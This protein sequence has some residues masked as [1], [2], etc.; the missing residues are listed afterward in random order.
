MHPK[1]LVARFLAAALTLSLTI[2]LAFTSA[3]PANAAP[4]AD[5]ALDIITTVDVFPVLPSKIQV[6]QEGGGSELTAVTWDTAS[7]DRSQWSTPGTYY[8][9]GSYAGGTATVTVTVTAERGLPE[10][11]TPYLGWNSWYAMTRNISEASIKTQ[12]LALEAKGVTAAGY[13]IIWLD[14]GWWQTSDPYR[15]DD[16]YIA[17][18]SRFPDMGA[19][20]D[21]LHARGL[22][23][24]LYADPASRACGNGYGFGGDNW[25]ENYRKDVAQM[26]EWGVDAIK[27]DHCGG[28]DDVRAGDEYYSK[29]YNFQLYAA[30]YQALREADPEG[31]IIFDTCEWGQENTPDWA[32][33]IA[34]GYRISDDLGHLA[35]PAP[36]ATFWDYWEHSVN[37]GGHTPGAYNDADYLVI[38]AL[39]T[40][41]TFTPAGFR[42]Y[43]S[44]WAFAGLP[45][46][47]STL[48]P[49]LA[50]ANVATITN[51]DMLSIDQDP[52]AIQPMLIREDYAGL[53]VWAR[54]L[55]DK[56][57]KKRAAVM[58][59]NRND[60][61][62]TVGF[63]WSDA[64]LA[65]VTAVRNVW[66]GVNEVP[67]A[68]YSTAVFPAEVTVLIAEG[69][70]TTVTSG[71][72]QYNYAPQSF[73]TVSSSTTDGGG[74]KS[75][76]RAQH[77]A[78]FKAATTWLPGRDLYGTNWIEV[79]FRQT[80]TVDSVVLNVNAAVGAGTWLEYL[81]GGDWTLAETLPA[82]TAGE[83]E[84]TLGTSVSTTAIRL[85]IPSGQSI[86]IREFE[87]YGPDKVTSGYT[88]LADPITATPVTPVNYFAGCGMAAPANPI[89]T[90]SGSY[91]ASYNAS[92][93]CDGSYSLTA[94][95]TA[96]NR[97]DS[98][99]SDTS[100]DWIAYAWDTPITD[101]GTLR[102][103]YGA[104]WQRNKHTV[105][106][107][108]DGTYGSDYTTWPVLAEIEADGGA[109]FVQGAPDVY[110]DVTG[111]TIQAL[112][113]NFTEVVALLGPNAEATVAEIELLSV[114]SRDPVYVEPVL[115]TVDAGVTPVLP[116]S[117]KVRYDDGTWGTA[118]VIW[119][120][121]VPASAYVID[122]EGGTYVITGTAGT[123]A[124]LANVVIV[125][126]PGTLADLQ[127]IVDANKDRVQADYASG[128]WPAFVSALAD[129]QA[130]LAADPEP[131]RSQIVVV[132]AALEDAVADL[133]ETKDLT[134]LVA[135]V[136]GA[137][138]FESEFDPADWAAFEQALGDAQGVL[139][140]PNPTVQ[141]VA[142]ALAALQAA[143]A[144]METENL[145]LAPKAT[146][147]VSS[148]Y[149]STS[150]ATATYGAG[151][152]NDGIRIT[153]PE[154]SATS[155]WN[156][157]SGKSDGEWAQLEW[158]SPVVVNTARVYLGIWHTRIGIA[159]IQ[160]FDGEDW[161]TLGTIA[162]T[163]TA[164]QVQAAA[165][166]D[167]PFGNV[168]VTK[169]RLFYEDA[170]VGTGTAAGDPLPCVFEIEVY[171]VPVLAVDAPAVADTLTGAA[172]E[173]PETVTLTLFGG[174]RVEAAVDWDS[175][176]S[177]SLESAGTFTVT[178]AIVGTSTSATATV[179]VVARGDTGALADLLSGARALLDSGTLTAAAI[180]ALEGPVAD[181][182]AMLSGS[183]DFTQA[184]VDVVFDAL[185][186][187]V[188]QAQL[189]TS[190]VGSPM[191]VE[192]LEALVTLA[193]AIPTDRYTDV[194]VAVLLEK[195]E[196]ARAVLADAGRSQADVEA[197]IAGVQD[198]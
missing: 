43:F 42:T 169:L 25:F 165:V 166:V 96:G 104:Y 13:D 162:Q 111:K 177:G 32:Y 154:N 178:G 72:P 65:N 52:L 68:S 117:V 40:Y 81:D 120:S 21:W 110:I 8:I 153:S 171:K 30:F 75:A 35:L 5:T 193:E 144:A 119:D 151:K 31:T 149:N 174:A 20:A 124:A 118:P 48:A 10:V 88:S 121:S 17:P 26:V 113:F 179:T 101:A 163:P 172:P 132:A 150:C 59:V 130:A 80:R 182:E 63:D 186:A 129:A 187:A 185:L 198:A 131:T 173:L 70:A 167:V 107:Y 61:P 100:N 145:A 47:L 38:D 175:I 55:A 97:W 73:I 11:A 1:P 142:D 23:L 164:G 14:E 157:D 125:P 57:G 19:F 116:D 7:I 24:G 192:L 18:N 122:A 78:D 44:A 112:R 115:I 93:V 94:V 159:H 74:N 77:V 156:S 152:L 12:V 127:A 54:P 160:Y 33:K 147:S 27:M 84:I 2:G 95:N 114:V 69:D 82:L 189:D 36:N 103:I 105:I 92:K 58:L 16:G 148:C 76:H 91:N 66:E 4:A 39:S 180:A 46:I 191:S 60:T 188:G 50:A 139:A 170:I 137:D 45:L 71:F 79:D 140:D 67:A 106:R 146:A 6:A 181:A 155:R 53:Q 86:E 56:D 3:P 158:A 176:P 183:P 90:E 126:R 196:A 62:G 138:A 194:S 98:G 195:L 9:T 143:V 133:V 37:P 161:V 102:V 28:H 123:M 87:V 85:V 51:A 134:A 109:G 136:T 184:Q 34:N 83:N 64:G 41:A 15:T 89:A 22:K 128:A 197:A 29:K 108:N 141:D 49:N 99:H 190:K 135:N 168:S